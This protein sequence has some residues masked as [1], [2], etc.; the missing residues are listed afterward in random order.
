MPDDVTLSG[1]DGPRPLPPALRD[2]LEVA[3]LAAAGG[4]GSAPAVGFTGT[5][6]EHPAELGSS[7]DPLALDAPRP[8][9]AAV[10]GRLESAML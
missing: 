5:V 8:L 7:E 10:R 4:A 9:P 2:R 6:P 3:L 1:L